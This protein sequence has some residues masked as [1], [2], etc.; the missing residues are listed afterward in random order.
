MLILLGSA[1]A[2]EQSSAKKP[3][4]KLT[5]GATL[6]LEAVEAEKHG[7]TVSAARL[8]AKA[9]HTYSKD[10]QPI[11]ALRMIERAVR[12][13]PNNL[14]YL[15]DRAQ[16]ANWNK[17]TALA[18]DSYRRMLALSDNRPDIL[19]NLARTQSWMGDLDES[20]NDYNRYL[21]TPAGENGDVLLEVAQ[22]EA[23]RGNYTKSLDLM[24]EY[25]GKLGNTL[26]YRKLKARVFAWA[27]RPATATDILQPM[28]Q[29]SPNDYDLNYTNTLV[30]YNG[31][32]P[33]EARASLD[34]LH[35]INPASKDTEALDVA[36]GDIH[37]AK[38]G[39]GANFYFDSDDITVLHVPVRGSVAI[40]PETQ[41]EIVGAWHR[42]TASAG[43]G[44]ERTDG[45]ESAVHFDGRLGVRHRFSPW[46][47]SRVHAGG[48]LSD[49][50]HKFPT[51]DAGLEFRPVDNLRFDLSRDYGYIVVSPRASSLGIRRGTN[52]LNLN[53]EPSLQWTI[54]VQSSLNDSSDDNWNW[55]AM[56]GPR[57]SILRTEHVNLDLGARGSWFGYQDRL[58]N[59]YYAPELYQSY[60]ATAL[61]YFKID[62]RNGVGLNGGLGVVKD[63]TIE[64]FKIGGEASAA[65]Y[66]ALG[67]GWLFQPRVGFMENMR[68]ATGAFRAISLEGFLTYSFD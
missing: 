61:F 21:E 9:A 30:L 43:S 35:E 4:P 56:I 67:R 37:G 41:L 44:F 63:D 57:R 27:D 33:R 45:A 38:I 52:Q 62:P 47:G 49:E 28:L 64:N 6:P 25:R 51:Y 20:V 11:E 32:R 14:K 1:R 16:L 48:A 13:Q 65:G 66:F 12:L 15:N 22:V 53:W 24:E 19:L 2:A 46:L 39:S 7:N 31:N 60:M 17:K 29:G 34:R 3:A 18:V 26:E 55:Q 59:G 10:N 58:T 5:G 40:Q 36:L 42:L 8:Y 23:W 50:E 54:P 68:Q